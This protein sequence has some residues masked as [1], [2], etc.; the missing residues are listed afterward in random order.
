M[1][2]NYKCNPVEHNHSRKPNARWV[3]KFPTLTNPSLHPPLPLS[4]QLY[5]ISIPC[6]VSILVL[7]SRVCRLFPSL[8]SLFNIP[9]FIFPHFVLFEVG[10][11][12]VLL[13][14]TVIE[15]EKS[16]EMYC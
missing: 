7:Y 10:E 15:V 8:L 3:R 14:V 2:S 13:D 1:V 12:N 16:T 5:P 9:V 11:H 4:R 6:L